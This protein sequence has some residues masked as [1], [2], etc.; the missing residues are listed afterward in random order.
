M[1]SN[2]VRLRVTCTEP[3][4]STAWIRWMVGLVFFSEGIQKW[5]QPDLRGAGRFEQI[6]LPAPE[7]LGYL[8]GSTEI[9]CGLL[10]VLGY[11]ARV[12]VLP[13]LIIMVVALL[14][15]KLP[16]LLEEGFWYAAHAVRTDFCM[17]LGSI[18]IL[19]KGAGGYSLDAR[20]S[21][22]VVTTN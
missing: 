6:G 14:S 15:T 7:L 17:I 11:F 20:T 9:I 8:V 1:N 21:K 19:L 16:I 13:L 18:F 12:A 2:K 10:I 22:A 4:L 5:I 3:S